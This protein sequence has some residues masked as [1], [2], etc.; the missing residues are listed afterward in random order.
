MVVWRVEA[1]PRYEES[2]REKRV[3]HRLDPSVLSHT[4]R[5]TGFSYTNANTRDGIANYLLR[6]TGTSRRVHLIKGSHLSLDTGPGFRRDYNVYEAIVLCGGCKNNESRELEPQGDSKALTW[7]RL[8]KA[9]RHDDESKDGLGQHTED[10]RDGRGVVVVLVL[11][12]E[13]PR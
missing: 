11:S 5:K 8:G 2:K 1:I 4:Q 3:S 10:D 6:W 12:E 7:S 13:I 9:N